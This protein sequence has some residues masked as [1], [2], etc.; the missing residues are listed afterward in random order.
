[1]VDMTVSS[2]KSIGP[3][4]V[5]GQ[6]MTSPKSFFIGIDTG[7]TYTDAAV[8]EADGHKVIASAKALTTKVI[9]QSAS[10]RQSRALLSRCCPEACLAPKAIFRLSRYRRRT[11]NERRCRRPPLARS[12]LFLSVLIRQ[13]AER[14]GIA[15]AFPGSA[16]F[17]LNS[18]AGGHDHN[19]DATPPPTGCSRS[20]DAR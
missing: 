18:F 15:K 10:A 1:M 19:G 17:F 7:G 11:G 9:W 14:T 20:C 8:I 12:A 13:M 5:E 4:T 16:D 6:A 3:M 2:S